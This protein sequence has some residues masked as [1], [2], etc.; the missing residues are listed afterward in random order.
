MGNIMHRQRYQKLVDDPAKL[1]VDL[2]TPQLREVDKGKI[3]KRLQMNEHKLRQFLQK[4][5]WI[6]RYFQGFTWFINYFNHPCYG[7]EWD[8]NLRNTLG[9]K[10]DYKE[11]KVMIGSF[12]GE[13]RI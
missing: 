3:S 1:L 2:I 4:Q 8:D 11:G 7:L 12:N 5:G 9:I 6:E 13:G 10:I